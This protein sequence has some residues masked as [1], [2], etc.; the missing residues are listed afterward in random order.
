MRL[1]PEAM[2]KN[3]FCLETSRAFC[4]CEILPRD[5]KGSRLLPG[6]AGSLG[7]AEARI[8]GPM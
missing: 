7:I 8:H 2:T 6:Q 3:Q 1:K 4:P 5:D